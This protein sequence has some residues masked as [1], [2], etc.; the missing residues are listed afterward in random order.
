MPQLSNT[1][2]LLRVNMHHHFPHSWL[3]N[4]A[5]HRRIMF[6]TGAG[7]PGTFQGMLAFQ[8]RHASLKCCKMVRALFCLTP[9]EG[10]VRGVGKDARHAGGRESPDKP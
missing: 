1:T 10:G 8:Q 3:Q 6:S 9:A 4:H 5:T 7:R 2:S